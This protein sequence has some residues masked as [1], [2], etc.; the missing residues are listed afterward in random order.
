MELSS[1][2]SIRSLIADFEDPTRVQQRHASEVARLARKGRKKRCKCGHCKQCL[3]E[4]RWDRIFT[5]KFAD[6]T[7][8]NHIVI[9]TTSPLTSI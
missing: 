6:P 9:H 2:E 7:Y 1:P 5:E 4:A 8:Y 3:D